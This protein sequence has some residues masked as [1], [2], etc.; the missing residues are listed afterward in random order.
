MITLAD[1]E[2]KFQQAEI[3]GS[4]NLR[5]LQDNPPIA[6]AELVRMAAR[7]RSDL[8][9]GNQQILSRLEF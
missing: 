8:T 2:P 4:P 6:P 1:C 3:D 7:I 5:A 9:T